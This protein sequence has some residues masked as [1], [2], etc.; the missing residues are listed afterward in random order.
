VG[1]LALA[2]VQFQRRT[3][4]ESISATNSVRALQAHALTRSGYAAAAMLLRT[5]MNQS[6][7]DDR[8]EAWFPGDEAG[9]A[10]PIPVNSD[11]V[12]IRIEDQVGKFPIGA[13]LD[14][15]GAVLPDHL[16]A[17]VKLFEGL[18]FEDINPDDL[19]QA[20]VD[21]I[22]AD[23]HGEYEYN[24]NFTVPN[25]PPEHIDELGRIELFDTLSPAQLAELARHLDTRAAKE[26]NAY[27][28]P[29]A[30]L[31]AMNAAISFDDAQDLYDDLPGNKSLLG[32]YLPP[33][34]RYLPFTTQ[35]TRFRILIGATVGGVTRKVD[36]IIERNAPSV[37]LVDWSQY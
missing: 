29:P 12:T 14:A 21:W 37:K 19:A 15:Q 36:C 35:S 17:L 33:N 1:L 4:L 11:V 28:A 24:E 27:T 22:D 5:D 20:L 3:H 32:T 25:T 6:T 23:N 2:V 30:V 34:T 31:Y 26:I 16:R 7:I 8:N 9:S 13:L 10:M 18:D